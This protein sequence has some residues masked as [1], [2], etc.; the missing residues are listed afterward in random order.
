MRALDLVISS[1]AVCHDVQHE[2]YQKY[3]PFKV[4]YEAD[5][6][7]V[8]RAVKAAEE[9]GD[10]TCHVGRIATGDWFIADRV[11]KQEIVEQ[12]HPLAVEMEG[13]A[14]AYAAYLNHC[15]FV[16]IRTMSDCADEEADESYDNLIERAAHLSASIALKMVTEER[17][18]R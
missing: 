8:S 16:I 12:F 9:L 4:A 6:T 14:V 2:I 5:K 10:I 15:P 18:D 7:L 3:Y 11:K 17:T 1:D 13:G